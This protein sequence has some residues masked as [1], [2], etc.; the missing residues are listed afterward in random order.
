MPTLP[1]RPWEDE[2]S[3][4]A[5]RIEHRNAAAGGQA[6]GGARK[7]LNLYGQVL[8]WSEDGRYAKAGGA[9]V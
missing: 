6:E 5:P 7:G 1:L 4:M 2:A 9:R 3:V 8:A